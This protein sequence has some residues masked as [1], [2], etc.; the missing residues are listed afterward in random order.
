MNELKC[1]AVRGPAR[2]PHFYDLSDFTLHLQFVQLYNSCPDWLVA[3][4]E[5]SGR[6]HKTRIRG[7]VVRQLALPLMP[8]AG[9]VDAFT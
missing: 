9:Q 6:R 2:R 3:P 1:C 7:D 4:Q 5:T 8:F